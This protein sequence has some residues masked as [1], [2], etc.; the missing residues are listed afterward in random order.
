MNSKLD[1]LRTYLEAI[2]TSVI[3]TIGARASPSNFTSIFLTWGF[4]F[5]LDSPPD[6]SDIRDGTQHFAKNVPKIWSVGVVGALRGVN[7]FCRSANEYSPILNL[8][9]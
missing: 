2:A 3:S 1:F 4:Q 5:Q 7:V 6:Q 8:P 9:N